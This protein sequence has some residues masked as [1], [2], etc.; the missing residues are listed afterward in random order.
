MTS[1]GNP[2]PPHEVSQNENYGMHRQS[3]F[4]EMEPGTGWCLMEA[5]RAADARLDTRQVIRADVTDRN[6]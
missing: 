6:I 2:E 1:P 5:G 4:V 3:Y